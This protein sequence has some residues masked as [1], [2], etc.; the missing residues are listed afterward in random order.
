MTRSNDE[1]VILTEL[2]RRVLSTYRQIGVRINGLDTGSLGHQ[3][4]WLKSY[5]RGWFKCTENQ[6][7]WSLLIS[8]Q[9]NYTLPV[10]FQSCK[11]LFAE[12]PPATG[13]PLH[14]HSA[15]KRRKSLREKSE[16]NYY[17]ES[18]F[19]SALWVYGFY[20]KIR[21]TYFILTVLRLCL[22]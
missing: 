21:G 19:H 15:L 20:S 10:D 22:N 14:F 5:R 6:W 1:A 11:A 18:L 9:H 17:L 7:C 4:C 3:S 13:F 8:E 12:W 16:G 2:H